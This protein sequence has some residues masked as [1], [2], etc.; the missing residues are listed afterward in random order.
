MS[1]SLPVVKTISS[2]GAK[3]GQGSNSTEYATSSSH[4][5]S[6][7]DSGGSS[8]H[9]SQENTSIPA[10][11]INTGLV[12]SSGEVG[13]TERETSWSG[14]TQA[15]NMVPR[16]ADEVDKSERSDSEDSDGTRSRL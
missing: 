9:I 12:C 7:S 11:N 15:T 2:Q 6:L 14:E 13:D 8:S 1:G 5:T 4:F 10:S 3:V 16:T